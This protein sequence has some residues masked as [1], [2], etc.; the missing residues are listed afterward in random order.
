MKKIDGKQIVLIGT[1]HGDTRGTLRLFELLKKE[2]PGHVAIEVSPYG[3]MFRLRHGR[4]MNAILGRRIRR[5]EKVLGRSLRNLEGILSI[6]EKI[7]TPFEYRASIRYCRN[8]GSQL[9]LVDSSELSSVLIRKYWDSMISTEN[10]GKLINFQ[11]ET[12]NLLFHGEYLFAQRLLKEVDRAMIDPFISS[13]GSDLLFMEREAHLEKYLLAIY[14]RMESGLL[15]YVG[16]WQHLL[17]P[18]GFHTL[19]DRIFHLEPRRILLK[20]DLFCLP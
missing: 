15:A 8:S 11:D 2:R 9:H 4:K 5:L 14:S 10:I 20:P 17:Y 13:W 3:L 12:T 1:V 6:R 7:R 16:G 19:C 18:T